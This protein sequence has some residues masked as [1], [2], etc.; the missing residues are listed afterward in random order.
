MTSIEKNIGFSMNGSIHGK[1]LFKKMKSTDDKDLKKAHN[2]Y[3]QYRKKVNA[4]K[5][6]KSADVKKLVEATN[7]YRKK[8]IYIFEERKNS[9]QEGL[10]SSILEEFLFHLFKDL[11]REL[12]KESNKSLVLGKGNIYVS[13]SFTPRSF[14]D[15]F[16]MP[17][18]YVHTKDQDFVL[19]CNTF[20]NATPFGEN[21]IEGSAKIVIPAVAIECKTYIERNML[22]SCAATARRLKSGM[23]FCIYVVVSE[24]IKMGKAHPE[25]TDI[26]EVFILCKKKNSERE[27]FKKENKPPHPLH[28]KVALD[29]F[30]MVKKHLNRLWWAPEMALKR[31]RIICRP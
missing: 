19:G 24:Y 25:L 15:L 17:S 30:D 9:G 16:I 10:R 12:L 27:K 1:A 26:D 11:V 28:T 4:L 13:L 18:P 21:K 7:E 23:P 2:Y 22:D 5:V 3:I 31:G 6:V 29:L 20:L 8:V 14:K